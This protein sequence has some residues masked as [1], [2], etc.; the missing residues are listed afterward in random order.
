[1][2]DDADLMQTVARSLERLEADEGDAEAWR[3]LAVCQERLKAWPEAVKYYWAAVQLAPERTGWLADLRR[4]ADQSGDP[5]LS[6]TLLRSY[7]ALAPAIEAGHQALAGLLR[8]RRRPEEAIAVLREAIPRFRTPA[9][10][11]NQLAAVLGEEG[12]MDEALQAVDAAASLAPGWP[13][14]L[15]NRANIRL[16]LGDIDGAL[17][18]GAAAIARTEG[19]EQ[20]SIRLARALALL[21]AG[22]LEQGWAA[23]GVR[24]EPDYVASIAFDISLPRWTPEQPLA[25][26]RLLLVGEQGLGDEIM[27]A[28]AVPDLVEQTAKLGLAVIPRLV[29]LFARS[30]PTAEVTHHHADGAGPGMRRSATGIDL[31]GYDAYAPMGDLMQ[32][33]RPTIADFPQRA[34]YL[35]PDPDRVAYWRRTLPPGRRI[36]LTWKSRGGL[37]ARSRF[38]APFEL[39]RPLFEAPGVTVVNLQ[40]G[41]I[42]EEIELAAGW[43]HPLWLPPGL[44]VQNDLDDLAALAA[45]LNG[46]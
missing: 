36:G 41:G 2:T 12:R 15:Q 24:L 19:R 32:L 29:P 9:N 25:G 38:Y 33:I 42:D 40:Y 4:A 18:D 22:R 16:A 45:A 26:L 1:M 28:N 46:V 34:G 8:D 27:F 13:A 7:V 3:T 43:K 21:R 35:V 5:G 17:A 44:D 30:F 11:L 6:E 14:A 37:H 39:W 10:L 31:S 23:Y 20:A